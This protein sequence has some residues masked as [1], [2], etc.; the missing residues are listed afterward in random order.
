VT[1]VAY[2]IEHDL[3]T[4]E[5]R[6]EVSIE[7]PTMS[8]PYETTLTGANRAEVVAKLRLA[9]GDEVVDD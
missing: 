5:W 8:A 1:I 6:A 7:H 3:S 2:A 9:L 4:D